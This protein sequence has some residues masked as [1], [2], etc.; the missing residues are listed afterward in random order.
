[1]PLEAPKLDR[2]TFDDIYREALLRIPRYTPEWT[3]FNE[4][5]PGITL[6]QLYTWLTEMMLFEM[7]RVPERN[8]IKFLQLLNM[9][10]KPAL[11]AVAHIT[12]TTQTGAKAP[13]IDRYT[14]VSAQAPDTGEL[15][16]FETET[17]L[18]LIESPLTDVQVYDSGSFTVMSKTNGTGSTS[19]RPFGWTPQLGNA[20]YLGFTPANPPTSNSPFPQQMRFRVFMPVD[21]LAGV[22]QS[23]KTAVNRPVAPVDL[24]WEYKLTADAKRW[25]QLNI[26]EDESIAFTQE[27]YILVE[28]PQQIAPTIEGKVDEPRYWLRCRLAS[29][30]YPAGLAPNID[31]IRANTVQVKNLTT[32]RQEVLGE[33]EG[34]P[35]QI[36]TLSRQPVVADTLQLVIEID[37]E[38]PKEWQQVDTLLRSCADDTHY[39]INPNKGEIRFGDGRKG[40]IPVAGALI[41]AYQYRTG[42]GKA[43]NVRAGLI[44][45]PVNIPGNLEITNE[46]PAVG[47]RNEQDIEELKAEAPY[48]L[49]SRNRAVTAE[50][51]T[52]LAQQAGGIGKAIAIPQMHPEFDYPETRVPGAI[53]VVI[54]P[55]ND[56]RQPLPSADEIRHMCT[57]LDSYRLLTSEVYVKGPQYF[58]IKVTVKVEAHPYASFDKV[59][60]NI[61]QAIDE[62]L[63]P[64]GRKKSG[65]REGDGWP[66]GKEFYPNS[67][68][69]VILNVKDVVAVSLPPSVIVNGRP[70]TDLNDPIIIPIDGLVFSAEDHEIVV[71]PVR[72][73]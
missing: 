50:D 35:N 71:V 3:D 56:E 65:E 11:P 10:L 44:N 69:H 9:E 33:S 34:H 15:L 54:V 68:Y 29:P 26:Y 17:G 28:G 42:G 25:R 53:T 52:A 66:F 47:G 41:V 40:Q 2:R 62:Y 73:R 6:L 8:Y 32:V 13:A 67:L 63:D 31:F 20:L 7:N 59:T 46:R 49:R 27:G 51:F 16:I 48:Q 30:S 58:K 61:I 23:C 55:E 45:T 14:Q 39:T 1:M 21:V 5:D 43:G 60:E 19:F 4:S 38:T 36:F 72:D 64:L 57:Y 18:D 24:I 22:A 37:G 70:I 12:F